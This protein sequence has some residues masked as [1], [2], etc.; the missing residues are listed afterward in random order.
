MKVKAA[1]YQ[2]QFKRPAGT[3]RGVLKTKQTYFV[4]IEHNGKRGIGECGLFKGLSCDD[5]PNYERVLENTCQR[6]MDLTLNEDNLHEELRDWPSIRFGF[7]MAFKDLHS[8][9]VIQYFDT[10]FYRGEEGIETN[11]L[12][13]MGSQDF[14]R[15]QLEKKVSQGFRCI[16][17]KI[18]AL[19][20]D[21]E[22]TMLSDVRK[23]YPSN[24]M[25]IRVDAN[26]A[27]T[28]EN[29]RSRLKELAALEIHSIEQPVKPSEIELL[30][31]LCAEKILPIALDESLI[32][33]NTTW[34]K[35][36]LLEKI[37]PQYIILKP[38]LIGGWR[39]SDEWIEMANSLEIG[40]WATSALESN[41]GLSAIA[42]WT[43]T[44]DITMPQGLG[45]GGLFINNIEGPVTLKDTQLVLRPTVDW[46]YPF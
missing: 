32:G 6:V 15:T 46:K 38:T 14:M 45:T 42:Q 1:P 30:S 27:F 37:K 31:E 44:K 12:I 41:I 20:W 11:G 36:S 10:A 26:G 16:K 33:I 29:V 39:A 5:R 43:S 24:V 23:L 35:R 9:G 13:W 8:N 34:E 4:I 3:S 17:F 28:A 21:K 19:D 18:G 40:W 2:L 7:E 22:H 25:E